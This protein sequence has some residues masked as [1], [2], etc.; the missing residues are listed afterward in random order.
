MMKVTVTSE[1]DSLAPLASSRAPVAHARTHP[2]GRLADYA[3]LTKPRIALLA[4][5]TVAAG[6]LLGA[7]SGAEWRVLLHTLL[8]AGLVAA[9][10][11]AL[12]HL[13]ERR[14]DARMKRTANRP[15]PAG[16]LKPEEAAAFGAGL[17]GAG[18]AYLAATVPAPAT[19]AAAIT[20]LA[21]AFI[22]TPLKTVTAWNTAVGAVPGALPPVIGWYAAR[23]WDG[24]AGW[25]GAAILFGVLFLWQIPHVLAIAW[26][27]R[28]DYAAAGLKML[29]GCD[30]TGRLTATVMLLT[31]GALIPLVW[32]APGVHIGSW[33]FATGATLFGL[34]F[35]QRAGAFALDRSEQ[36]ARRVLRASLLYL[37]GVFGVLLID[38][39]LVNSK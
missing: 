19:V 1:V 35:L 28:D 8:G 5:F 2:P 15:L 17:A 6:Y 31:A 10:G 34:F 33:L 32:L 23:G 7:G 30:A 16:R 20:F 12:N 29:P 4:L 36:N 11:S 39:L 21:Y 24:W 25:E 3:E 26:M 13:F 18:L 38:T 14:I 9:G 27:Y 22:Y 37:P